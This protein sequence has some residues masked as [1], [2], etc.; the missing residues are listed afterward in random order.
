LK[1]ERLKSCLSETGLEAVTFLIQEPTIQ[2]VNIS[3]E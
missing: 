1:Q 3:V 2:R